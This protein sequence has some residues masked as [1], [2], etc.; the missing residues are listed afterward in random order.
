M[1]KDNKNINVLITGAGTGLGAYMAKALHD[2]GM[3]V[4]CVS[5]EYE[6]EYS[7]DYLVFWGDIFDEE[8]MSKTF[9][10]I[11]KKIGN[12][13]VLINNI[14]Y[15]NNSTVEHNDYDEY[16]KMFR[17]NVKSQYQ[18][19]KMCI[20]RNNIRRVINI[21]S[22]Y[23]KVTFPTLGV[24]AATKTA[25]L[26]LTRNLSEKYKNISFACICPGYMIHKKHIK[27]FSTQE[28]H[29]FLKYRIPLRRVGLP[30]EELIPAVLLCATVLKN[31]RYIEL[32]VDGG[33]SAHVG[34]E[35]E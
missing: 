26:E 17:L 11:S 20:A 14:G 21:A 15:G 7:R 33:L 1:V 19:F 8:F 5:K 22:A 16:L 24:Y 6:S 10:I 32:F 2:C 4:I 29:Y 31:I 3:N 30:K 35:N 12:I 9:D 23:A 25:S 34:E 13:D 18:L 28:G 27:Y